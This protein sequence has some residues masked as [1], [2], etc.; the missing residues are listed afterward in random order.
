MSRLKGVVKL[1]AVPT[2]QAGVT[3]A[4]EELEVIG[5]TMAIDA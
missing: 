5:D 1:C 2:C 4:T 3:G